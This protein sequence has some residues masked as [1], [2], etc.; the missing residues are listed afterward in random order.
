[1]LSLRD[2]L[3]RLFRV[4]I[5]ERLE[6]LREG[7]EPLHDALVEWDSQADLDVLSPQL[8]GK[9]EMVLKQYLASAADIAWCLSCGGHTQ[10]DPSGCR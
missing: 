9:F 2:A 8:E 1:M 3:P 7:E 5:L 4:T 10:P 6:H